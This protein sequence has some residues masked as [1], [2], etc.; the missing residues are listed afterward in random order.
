M[1]VRKLRE[2]QVIKP[3]SKQPRIGARIATLEA[4]LINSLPEKDYVLKKEGET[5]IETAW[6]GN[7]ENP[8]VIHQALSGKYKESG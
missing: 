5:P 7:R 3:V 1:Q 4:Q 8:M 6:G 2:Q